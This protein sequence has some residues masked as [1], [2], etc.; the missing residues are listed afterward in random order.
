MLFS[1]KLQS[2]RTNIV[3]KLKGG[4]LIMIKGV[5]VK[6]HPNNKQKTK[7]FQCA[8]V[9]RW[10]YNWTLSRQQENYRS[11]GKFIYDG[12]LRKELTQLKKLPDYQW[13]N[14]YS[15]NITKQAIK[16]ACNAYLKF[17]EGLT[18]FPQFKSK[19]KSDPKFYQDNLKIKFTSTHVK[20]EKLTDS[21]K[22]NKQ[23]F[24]WVR[25]AENNRIPFGENNKY[26]NPRVSFDGLN[27]WIS[28]GIEYPDNLETP[29]NDGIGIDLGIKDLAI[30]SDKE[31][32]KNINK[33]SKVKRIEKRLIRKQRRVS[34]KYEMNKEG[35]KLIKTKNINKL[36][37]KIRRLHHRLAGIRHNY[38]HQV[39]SEII[40]RKPM[41]IAIE[42]LHV[43]GMMKNRNIAKAVQEQR[44]YEFTRQ[45]KYKA[46]WNGV[47]VIVADRFFPSSKLCSC[48][49]NIKKDL[50]LSDRTYICNECNNVI[51]RDY[52][53][54]L[55]L[56]NYGLI[57]I[58]EKRVQHQ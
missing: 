25:L 53:A 35:N 36:E 15:N 52:Q 29:T 12:E 44:F 37:N 43:R 33:T 31:T 40:N 57:K 4:R 26:I 56:R 14:N 34:R 48:C 2:K 17:F 24:N 20:F 46:E 1:Y 47:K 28:V 39:T 23:T 8:G 30:C 21:K 11:G 55:N 19:K 5:K 16:D 50:K 18:K 45:L 38:S 41:F 51:D 6:L 10:A 7:L 9:A 22:T 42:D 49:G 54:S 27:W 32:Y 3:N 13:L 58:N